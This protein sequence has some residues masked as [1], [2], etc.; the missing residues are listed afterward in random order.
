MDYIKTR[1]DAL[2][3]RQELFDRLTKISQQES[4][5]RLRWNKNSVN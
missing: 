4:C 1:E 5:F 3:R 2:R